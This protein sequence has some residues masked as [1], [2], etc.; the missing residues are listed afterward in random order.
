MPPATRTARSARRCYCLSS[1]LVI[2]RRRLGLLQHCCVQK[3]TPPWSPRETLALS[4]AI[5][6]V[7]CPPC[8]YVARA[9]TRGEA[10]R[11]GRAACTP[12]PRCPH[13]TASPAV[14]ATI[15]EFAN[16]SEMFPF[17][18]EDVPCRVARMT[19]APK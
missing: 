15:G 19:R 7:L 18:G 6:A 10:T 4:L 13:P 16:G 14:E 2:A 17:T 1:P 5:E 12:H 9:G 11:N 8:W 3:G